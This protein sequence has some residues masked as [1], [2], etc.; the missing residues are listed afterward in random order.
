[1]ISASQDDNATLGCFLDAQ[2]MQ[3]EPMENTYPEV[4]CFTAQSE[5]DMPERSLPEAS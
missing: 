4:E 1:M 2:L 5:S 3:A